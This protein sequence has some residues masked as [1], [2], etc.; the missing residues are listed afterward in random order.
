MTAWWPA[1]ATCPSWPPARSSTPSRDVGDDDPT[2][3]ELAAG[4]FRDTS[5][6]AASDTQMFLDILMTNRTAVLAQ[7]DA[8]HGAAAPNCARCWTRKMKPL[9][10]KL[11]ASRNAKR[12]TWKANR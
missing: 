1:S 4:G 6:V 7:F 8:S 2:V 10:A 3:W 5:R 12:A 9:C 11:A